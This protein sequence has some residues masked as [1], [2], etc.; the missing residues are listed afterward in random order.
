MALR[1]IFAPPPSKCYANC[2]ELDYESLIVTKCNHIYCKACL[3]DWFRTKITCP[4]DNKDLLPITDNN[5][6][7]K[8]EDNQADLNQD[9]QYTSFKL[10][11][12]RFTYYIQNDFLMLQQKLAAEKVIKLSTCELLK[13]EKSKLTTEQKEPD[14]C[15]ICKES[16]HLYFITQDKNKKRIGRFMH[17]NCWQKTVDDKTVLLEISAVDVVKFAQ[18]LPA[19]KRKPARPISPV[20]IFFIA[21]TLPISLWALATNTRIYHNKSPFRFVLSIPALIIFKSL[22][23]FLNGIR[24]ILAEKRV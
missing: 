14:Q 4:L 17:E 10:Y 3:E 8:E 6:R 5:V 16:F 7:Y 9:M 19:P 1:A 21:I 18:Q 13:E 20:T 15:S 2:E 12:E 24:A 22:S 11:L 23:L